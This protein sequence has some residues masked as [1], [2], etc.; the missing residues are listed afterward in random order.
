MNPPDAAAVAALLHREARLLDERQFEAWC[1]LFA[2]DGIYWVPARAGQTD[3]LHEVSL[4]HDDRALM[5]AR[6][7][8]LRHPR[9]HAETPPSRAVRAVSNIE[10]EPAAEGLVEAR[11]VLTMQEYREGRTTTYMGRVAWRLVSAPE[12]GL[13]IRLKR[14]DLVNAEAVHGLMTVPF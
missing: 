5:A 9:M 13:R 11:S 12:G 14:V 7:R 4:F 2:A 10:V 1:E 3:P 8:R 6:C